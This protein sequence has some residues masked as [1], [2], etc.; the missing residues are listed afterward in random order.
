MKRSF[1]KCSARRKS[2][3]TSALLTPPRIESAQKSER[4]I[5][6][7]AR[8]ENTRLPTEVGVPGGSNRMCRPDVGAGPPLASPWGC[9]YGARMKL[10]L[11]VELDP[12]TKRWS[13]VFP[14]LP[15]CASAGDSEAEAIANAKEALALWFDPAPLKLRK[16]A[17]LVELAVP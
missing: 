3:L 1:G 15:G 12:G 10:R 17:K 5:Y 8:S 6:P 16:D 4:R 2:G 9:R 7:A 13:A 11:I 14:E